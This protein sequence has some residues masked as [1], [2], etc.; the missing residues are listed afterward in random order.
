MEDEIKDMLEKNNLSYIE[1]YKSQWLGLQSLDFYLPDYKIAIECQG[2][3]H[4]KPI[5][6][7]GGI[8]KLNSI[9]NRDNKKK[10]KCSEQGIKILY[11]SNL[12]IEYPYKV[13]TDKNNLIKEITY[14]YGKEEY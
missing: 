10:V 6:C 12:K 14:N 13:F 2:E 9:I 4:F 11:Y 8:D 5:K 3:Q 7:F 1:Q